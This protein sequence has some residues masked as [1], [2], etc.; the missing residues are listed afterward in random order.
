MVD[1]HSLDELGDGVNPG[2]T[3]RLMD[4][5]LFCTRDDALAR[6]SVVPK[7]PGIYAWYFDVVPDG[8]PL[9]GTHRNHLG[10]LLYVGIAPRRPRRSDLR[11]S[12]QQLRARIRTHYRRMADASTLRLMLGTLL[13]DALD[14][15]LRPHGT[16]ARLTFGDGEARL[17]DWMS[18]HAR[19]A[20]TVEPEPWFSEERILDSV[21]LPLNLDRNPRNP[22]AGFLSAAR[23]EQRRRARG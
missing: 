13:A 7:E 18:R 2:A 12:A 10:H 14:L 19:V 21:M 20:W 15:H 1:R 16:S 22:F 23:A 5:Q 3:S 4:A 8:V 6:P 11:P 17:S 9:E